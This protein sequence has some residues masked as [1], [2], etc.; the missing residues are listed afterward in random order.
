MCNPVEP[1]RSLDVPGQEVKDHFQ[2][3]NAKKSAW[4][5][6]LATI[7][8]NW[9]LI[10]IG[11]EM[12]MPTVI[13]GSLHNNPAEPLNMNDDQA[14]WF[15]SIPD[16]CHPIGSLTSG[17]LQDKFGRKGAMMLINIPIFIGWMILYF[18]QSI[19]ALYAVSVIMGLCTGLAEAPLHAYIG[20]IGEPRMR[21]T[22]STISTSCCTIGVCAMFLFGYLFDWRTV[23][24]VSSSCSIITFTFM[25]QL[26]ESPT[27]LIVRGRLDEAKKSLCWLRGWVSSAEVEPEFQSL[28]NYAVKSADL[29]RENSAD[30]SLPIKE[31]EPVAE[32]GGFLKQQLKELTNK[33]TFRPLRL[34]FF[35]FIITNIACVSG[36]MPYF[37]NELKMLESPIDPNLAL[38]MCSGL[39]FVGAMVNVVFLRRF[40]KRKIALFSHILTGI[41]IL[42][43]GMYASFLQSLTQYPLRVW[44]PLILWFIMNFLHGFSIITLPWQLVCEVFPPLGRGTATGLAAAWTH[45]FMS[46]LTK[47]YLY[48]EAWLGFSGVMYLY[49][50]CTMAGVIY[51][52]FYLPETE[53]KTL[54]QIETY[55]T[56]NHDKREKFSVGKSQRQRAQSESPS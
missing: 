10:E 24:L 38:M 6:I 48:M 22:L 35:V 39:F 55:F 50:V 8:Q 32:R 2:Y 3:A 17:L 43:V 56:K 5:Q 26:P 16:F 13:I 41:C 18:A 54:E 53:G 34:M 19:H 23:A 44:L 9:L 20:E 11:L 36:I 7:M 4:A 1:S 45:F 52:Y 40:G 33:R 21:G 29:S 49:G 37:V 31:G 47:T 15:G 27:W 46:V 14:S 25:T 12:V 42:S 51:H 28:V 30:S